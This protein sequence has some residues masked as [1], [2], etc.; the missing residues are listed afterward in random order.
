M[1]HRHIPKNRL[2]RTV[3]TISNAQWMIPM[4]YV[5]ATLLMIAIGL[6]QSWAQS[7]T[8]EAMIEQA[9]IQTACIIKEVT[10][11]SETTKQE[12]RHI[13]HLYFLRAHNLSL[14]GLH[15][16]DDIVALESIW[17]DQVKNG[18]EPSDDFDELL[19]QCAGP[20]PD[21]DDLLPASRNYNKYGE[22][23]SSFV[24]S[25]LDAGWFG[26]T[27]RQLLERQ[28]VLGFQYKSKCGVETGD[29]QSRC[30]SNDAYATRICEEI[31]R[32]ARSAREFDMSTL[33]C[34]DP[35]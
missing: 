8:A 20:N 27:D 3:R 26:S 24:G 15:I 11:E 25:G 2:T 7:Q 31:G 34:S 18:E 22:R 4:K 17:L 1:L 13:V 35:S 10:D 14:A 23:N 29:E 19:A 12:A 33:P 32:G 5:T 9:Q 28:K 21:K 16:Y 6:N 30:E